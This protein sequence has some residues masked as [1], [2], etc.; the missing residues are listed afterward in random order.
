MSGPRKITGSSSVSIIR[1]NDII[2]IPPLLFEG[3]IPVLLTPALPVTPKIFGML[4]PVM[5]A[6][7]T[8]TLYPWRIRVTA[9]ILVTEDLP[10]PPLPLMTAITLSTWLA[11]WASETLGSLEQL[12]VV[13]DPSAEQLLHDSLT[14]GPPFRLNNHILPTIDVT[15]Q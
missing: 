13:Q 4:G 9:N 8:P 10:T 2:L 7:K 11:F 14:M 12:S 3:S 15:S 1:F 5:S 6:S